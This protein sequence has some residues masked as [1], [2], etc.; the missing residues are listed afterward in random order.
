MHDVENYSH[1]WDLRELNTVAS[2]VMGHSF[3][4]EATID[5]SGHNQR[6]QTKRNRTGDYGND[7]KR[8]PPALVRCH[9]KPHPI[10]QVS[11]LP[12]IDTNK[13]AHQHRMK[14]HK[15]RLE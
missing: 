5:I 14:S 12:M 7:T 13:E 9:R 11:L 15:D 4:C 6:S 3:T 1:R 8:W 10:S 2:V